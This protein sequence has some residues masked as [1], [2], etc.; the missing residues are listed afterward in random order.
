MRRVGLSVVALLVAVAARA[1]AQ[2]N[3]PI[4][5]RNAVMHGD[6]VVKTVPLAPPHIGRGGEAALTV[7]ADRWR[8]RLRGVAEH[9]RR[10]D[11]R[12]ARRSSP[13]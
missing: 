10:D 2:G 7:L 5:T 3:P 11:S 1:T 12:D 8:R 9:S 4:D 13:R 6:F